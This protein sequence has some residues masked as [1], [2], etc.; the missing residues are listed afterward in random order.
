MGTIKSQRSKEELYK[1]AVELLTRRLEQ[2]GIPYNIGRAL[3]GAQETF[4]SYG[5]EY[6]KQWQ[7][8]YLSMCREDGYLNDDWTVDIVEKL[9][10]DI[11]TNPYPYH[12]PYYHN[13]PLPPH[14][15]GKRVSE[16]KKS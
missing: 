14:P 8:V 3:I 4:K 11:C 6:I 9:L 5:E 15:F 7:D 10:T 12:S 2:Y 16:Y 13:P 1:E